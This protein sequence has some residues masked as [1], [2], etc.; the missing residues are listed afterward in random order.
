MLGFPQPGVT[1]ALDFPNKGSKTLKL[2]DRLDAIVRE[3]G[4]RVY[5]AKDARISRDFFETSY[6][7]LQEFLPYRDPGITSAMSRR[8][9]GS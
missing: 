3:V 6:S 8:L 9:M 1:L 7:R 5:L 4:G 2:F